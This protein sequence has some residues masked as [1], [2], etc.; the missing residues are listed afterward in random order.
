MGQPESQPKPDLIKPE[1]V[2][3]K[4]VL[5]SDES[6]TPC[7]QVRE[8]LKRYPGKYEIIDPMDEAA[9]QFWKESQG[10]SEDSPQEQMEVPA[11]FIQG[12][13]KERICDV[14]IDEQNMIL[15]CDGRLLI[16]REPDT[17]ASP[18]SSNSRDSP[19][20]TY[21][22]PKSVPE[23][24][25]SSMSEETTAADWYR[26]RAEYSEA[27]GDKKSALLWREIAGEE[28]GHYQQF[29]ERAKEVNTESS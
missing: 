18:P 6:C 7:Q 12:D 15:R 24:L 20:L 26:R 27:K 17:G 9:E 21:H 13:G 16:V 2:V 19:G 5:G 28:D 1:D 10:E 14:F 22:E 29:E 8:H 25:E 3:V 23:A 4:I 11:A